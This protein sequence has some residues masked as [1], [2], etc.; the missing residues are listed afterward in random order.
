MSRASQVLAAYSAAPSTRWEWRPRSLEN[1]YV[2]RASPSF[3]DEVEH[4]DANCDDM[5][6]MM[7]KLNGRYFRLKSGIDVFRKE[8]AMGANGMATF[9]WHEADRGWCVSDGP[10]DTDTRHVWVEGDIDSGP[11]GRVHVPRN[12]DT[13]DDDGAFFWT[14]A[15][16]ECM[17]ATQFYDELLSDIYYHCR[18]NLPLR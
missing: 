2:I 9:L 3:K 16:R 1:C 17:T 8:P 12:T 7:G 11:V 13:A 14:V 6:S 5:L 10:Y 15:E 4:A 18:A